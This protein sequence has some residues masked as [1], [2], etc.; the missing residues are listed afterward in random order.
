[1][2]LAISHGAFHGAYSAF[3]RFRKDVAASF[4]GSYPRHD[5]RDK[6]LNDDRWYWNIDIHADNGY[7]NATHPGLAVFFNH[8]DC[9]MESLLPKLDALPVCLFDGIGDTA[10]T[11]IA[12]CRLA[13]SLNEPLEFY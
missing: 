1:M 2:G 7:S 9:E 3:N 10:R 6:S 5:V 8:S 12:G 13:A 4:G 11:F